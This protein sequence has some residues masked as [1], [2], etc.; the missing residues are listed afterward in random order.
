MK[1]FIILIV[2]LLSTG[3]L[4]AQDAEQGD[5]EVV[6]NKP[7]AFTENLVVWICVAIVAVTLVITLKVLFFPGEKDPKHI[8]NIVIDEEGIE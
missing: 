2:L 5:H 7:D 6:F 4:W 3:F 8:K 1:K